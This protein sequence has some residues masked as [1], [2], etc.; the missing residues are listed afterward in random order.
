[1]VICQSLS[2]A[3]ELPKRP[4]TPP[5]GQICGGATLLHL[6]L[7]G[8]AELNAASLGTVPYCR[9]QCGKA[10]LIGGRLGSAGAALSG[11]RTIC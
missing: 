1:L 3:S 7:D 11:C 2:A 8:Y 5:S 10:A 6:A 9:R 4:S